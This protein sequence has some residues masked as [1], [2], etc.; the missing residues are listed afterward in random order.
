MAADK[1]ALERSRMVEEQLVRRGIRDQRVLTAMQDVPRH[2]FIP[3]DLQRQSY[4]DGPLPIGHG[5]TISQPYMVALM[6]ELLE[7]TG[8]EKVLEL[9]TGS[10]YETAVLARLCRTVISLERVPALAT[11]AGKVLRELEI[12]NVTVVVSDGTLGHAAQAPY[13]GI[14]VSAGA[15]SIPGPLVEQLD[16]NGRLVIPVGDRFIQTLVKGVK[17]KGKLET[18]EGLT[19]VFVPLIG[20]AG[21]NQN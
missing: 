13:Q 10:G 15:P 3:L 7:L 5:Q 8:T 19:C 2:N 21:W 11:T 16:E 12:A 20:Q 9:G 14:V 6:V 17:K 4:D 1:F 18:Q